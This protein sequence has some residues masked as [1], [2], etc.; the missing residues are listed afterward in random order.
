MRS[1]LPINFA[2]VAVTTLIF[3]AG[4]WTSPSPASGQTVTYT[5]S[6]ND[7]GASTY[8]PGDFAVYASDS[9]ADGN[10]GICAFS[11]EL[12]GYDAIVN[13]APYI[14]YSVS[15]DGALGGVGFCTLR[16]PANSAS[17]TGSEDHSGTY[18]ESG[19]GVTGFGQQAG[20]INV[21]F[22]PFEVAFEVSSSQVTTYSNPLL[23]GTGTF[24]SQIPG[25]VPSNN[26]F[27]DVII[28]T[29]PNFE[30]QSLDL[31]CGLILN[32]QTLTP[33]PEP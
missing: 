17:L 13:A 28:E 15:P 14:I 20:I 30:S 24:S 2:S 22:L 5:L 1:D 10:Q 18:P 16:S 4:I 26:N 33:V 11:T 32:T 7:N 9:T 12:D 25:W 27:A 19:R 29:G 3:F 23:L 21:P 6:I 31:S 8:T